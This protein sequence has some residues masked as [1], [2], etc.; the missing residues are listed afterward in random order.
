MAITEGDL[1]LVSIGFR[2]A[3]ADLYP[4]TGLGS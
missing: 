1:A 2:L 3:L 4:R